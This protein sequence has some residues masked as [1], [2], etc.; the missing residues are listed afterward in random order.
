M[1]QAYYL[2]IRKVTELDITFHRKIGQDI[3]DVTK[4][5]NRKLKDIDIEI[6]GYIQKFGKLSPILYE[7]LTGKKLDI[8]NDPSSSTSTGLPPTTTSK[9]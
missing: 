4:R 5:R 9:N 8:N 6:N 7:F 3:L 2:I 1:M